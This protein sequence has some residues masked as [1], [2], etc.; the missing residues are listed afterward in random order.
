M[1][2]V[3]SE[4]RLLTLPS[5]LLLQLLLL[6][7]LLLLQWLLL[8]LLL[9]GVAVVQPTE[10]LLDTTL[11]PDLSSSF[12]CWIRVW[13]RQKGG[14]RAGAHD[15]TPCVGLPYSPLLLLCTLCCLQIVEGRRERRVWGEGTRGGMLK[16]T[17]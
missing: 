12:Y 2:N 5:S 3:S 10:L 8:L 17:A 16:L 13:R 6:L 14:F 7:L 11:L 9:L 1:C 15:L 4:K